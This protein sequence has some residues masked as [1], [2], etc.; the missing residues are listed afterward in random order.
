MWYLASAWHA[1]RC[2]LRCVGAKL[3]ENDPIREASALG[4]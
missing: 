2:A 3:V 4:R 1:E